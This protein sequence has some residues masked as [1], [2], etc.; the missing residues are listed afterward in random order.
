MIYV[1]ITYL[2]VYDSLR[3]KW[4]EKNPAKHR[5]C[6]LNSLTVLTHRRPLKNVTIAMK[7]KILTLCLDR[8]YNASKMEIKF[9]LYFLSYIYLFFTL[10]QIK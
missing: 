2:F 8:L 4:V 6:I 9:F 3:E 10:R 5:K 7:G 1:N